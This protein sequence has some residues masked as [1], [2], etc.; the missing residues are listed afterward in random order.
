MPQNRVS[1]TITHVTQINYQKWCSVES[2][3]HLLYVLHPDSN[4]TFS[5]QHSKPIWRNF[6]KELS[7]FMSE[8]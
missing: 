2:E 7:T 5:K 3:H 6:L 4:E 8:N 1:D